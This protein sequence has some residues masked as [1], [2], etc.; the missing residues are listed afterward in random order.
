MARYHHN[1][2]AMSERP[3]Y[4]TPSKTKS[5]EPN[6]RTQRRLAILK[7]LAELARRAELDNKMLML[8]VEYRKQR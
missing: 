2:Y 1:V 4:M 3:N 6:G 8:R 5:R 7:Q